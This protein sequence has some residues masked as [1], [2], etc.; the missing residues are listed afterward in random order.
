MDLVTRTAV[1]TRVWSTEQD[2][3]NDRCIEIWYNNNWVPA[4][5]KDLKKGDF[6]LNQ[7]S[8]LNVDQCFLAKSDCRRSVYRS[9]VSF[10]IEGIEVVQAP[11]FVE[12][13]IYIESNN[14]LKGI[15]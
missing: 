4:Y 12:P 14:P 3:P 5:F 2:G 10:L 9:V 13:N 8:H 15:S 11:A 7:N 1:V 6:F